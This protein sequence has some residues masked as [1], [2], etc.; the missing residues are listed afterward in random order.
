MSTEQS[1]EDAEDQEKDG[2]EAEGSAEESDGGGDDAQDL[3]KKKEKE[4]E[5]A[6][7]VMKELEEGDL[8]DDIDGWPSGPA[9]Y[10]TFGK[11]DDAYG[12]GAT[13]K[14]GPP[15]LHRNKDGSVEIDG[16]KV[17]N[18]D[19][20]KGSPIAGG[21]DKDDDEDK[22]QDDTE[23][24]REKAKAAADNDSGDSDSDSGDDKDE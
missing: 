13:A 23:D 4:D 15:N 20:Y 10:E 5:E 21:L 8:P 16:E 11:D 14:L 6:A 1:Q 12:D 22:E 18:P 17:D 3:A 24:D 2:A 7:E 9:K 19:D